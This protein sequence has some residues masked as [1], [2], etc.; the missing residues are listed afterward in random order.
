MIFSGQASRSKVSAVSDSKE[1]GTQL[2]CQSKVSHTVL[3]L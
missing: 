3:A 1:T 2:T